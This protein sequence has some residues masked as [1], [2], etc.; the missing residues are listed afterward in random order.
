MANVD[1]N[2]KTGEKKTLTFNTKDK[3]NNE[4]IIFNIE[5]E[6]GIETIDYSASAEPTLNTSKEDT[7]NGHLSYLAKSIKWLKSK[8]QDLISD[9]A[10]IRSRAANGNTAYNW[11][12]HANAGYVN[13]TSLASMR[14]GASIVISS[15]SKWFDRLINNYVLDATLTANVAINKAD[16]GTILSECI[17]YE[18]TVFTDV[19]DFARNTKAFSYIVTSISKLGISVFIEHDTEDVCTNGYVAILEFNIKNNIVIIKAYRLIN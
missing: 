1:L 19:I 2:I 7:L 4:D 12:N 10:T 18:C 16:I 14:T 15:T 11:G 13:T 5:A 9:L 6:E 8:K 3:Y 17:G